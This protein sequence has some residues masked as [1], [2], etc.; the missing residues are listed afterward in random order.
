MFR[1]MF[2]KKQGILKTTEGNVVH[3]GF[4]RLPAKSKIGQDK[5]YEVLK[6]RRIDF[7]DFAES[8]IKSLAEE[9]G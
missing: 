5:K 3:Y 4:I 7:L 8:L 9:Y 2:G 1:M 6:D